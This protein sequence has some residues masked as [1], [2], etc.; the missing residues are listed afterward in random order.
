MQA[1]A[2]VLPPQDRPRALSVLGT[3][4][5]VLAD[6]ARTHAHEITLQEGPEGSGPPP[7]A[8]PWPESFYVLQGEVRFHCAGQDVTAT[9]GTLVHVP[10]G[11]VHGFAFGAGGATMLEIAGAGGAASAMFTALADELPPGPP[12]LPSVVDLLGRFR[13]EVAAQS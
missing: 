7:H 13:V 9:P 11:T 10:A 12:D 8:H 3:R 4:I 1:Q 2:I 5:T 6:S